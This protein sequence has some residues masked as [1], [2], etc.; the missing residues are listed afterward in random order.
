M[1]CRAVQQACWNR[2]GDCSYTQTSPCMLGMCEAGGAHWGGG[3]N[4]FPDPPSHWDPLQ[5]QERRERLRSSHADCDSQC[6]LGAQGRGRGGGLEL[7]SVRACR[8]QHPSAHLQPSQ[9]KLKPG[10]LGAEVPQAEIRARSAAMEA[11]SYSLDIP[12]CLH[13]WSFFPINKAYHVKDKKSD[14][15]GAAGIPL[16]TPHCTLCHPTRWDQSSRRSIL[17]PQ[18]DLQS[19][20][21]LLQL[22]TLPKGQTN[23]TARE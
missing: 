11:A 10:Q 13:F 8:A 2:P 21:A 12:L 5:P 6:A 3:L 19:Q 22:Y 1:P 17:P 15:D 14:G 16:H 7:P 20:L 23:P 9:G 18:Q 4:S